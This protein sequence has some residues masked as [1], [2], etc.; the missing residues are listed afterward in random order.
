V[1]T[2][3]LELDLA[4]VQERK[5]EKFDMF[6]TDRNIVKGHIIFQIEEDKEGA[7]VPRP[8]L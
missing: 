7:D 4:T 3:E 2:S 1:K 5:Y 8:L 6:H